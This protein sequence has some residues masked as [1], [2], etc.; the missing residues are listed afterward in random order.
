MFEKTGTWN[1]VFFGSAGLA[2]LASLGA[3]GLRKMPSPRKY[4]KPEIAVTRG[5]ET[6]PAGD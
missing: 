3:L 5:L 1:Y 6:A 2:L 4:W